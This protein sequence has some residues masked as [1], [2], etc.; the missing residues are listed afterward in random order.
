M[1]VAMYHSFNIPECFIYNY[2]AEV[3]DHM[4]QIGC[5]I[6]RYI[7]STYTYARFWK[8]VTLL[9]IYTYVY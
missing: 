9:C 4:S 6:Y 8:S 1:Y 2:S 5:V 7:V 3:V